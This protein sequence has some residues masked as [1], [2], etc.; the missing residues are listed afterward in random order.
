MS[1]APPTPKG[2]IAYLTVVGGEAA[3][4]FYITAFGG[5][6]IYRQISEDGRLLHARMAVNDG[7]LTLSDDYPEYNGGAS[8]A[9]VAGQPRGIVLHMAV[10]S[11]DAVF[12]QAV[13]AGA[14]GTM[15]PSDQF[16]GERYA[17]LR[18]PFGHEWSLGSPL[19]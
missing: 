15:P 4:R 19:A 11:C 18:D 10:D 3:V 1:D 14:E 2:V 16:W 17:R 8:M 13:A 7:I 12:A 6:E 9:P 5:R